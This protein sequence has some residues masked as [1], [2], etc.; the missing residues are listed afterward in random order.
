MTDPTMKAIPAR[1]NRRPTTSPAAARLSANPV[2]EIALGVSR[3][4]IKRLRISSCVVGPSRLRVRRSRPGGD[5]VVTGPGIW[6]LGRDLTE[7]PDRAGPRQEAV[8]H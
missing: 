8:R 3:D 5:G 7:G 6:V 4:S 1:K 2:S